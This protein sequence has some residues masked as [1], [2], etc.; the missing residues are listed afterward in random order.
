MH[1]FPRT[2]GGT[3]LQYWFFYPYNDRY[4]FF[5]HEGDWEHVTVHLDEQ[6]RPRELM[7]AQHGNNRPGESRPWEGVRLEGEHPIVLAARGDHASYPEQASMPWF[8]RSSG[9]AALAACASPIWR[10]WEGGGL[11]NIGERGA[12]LG[13]DGVFEYDGRW[14]GKGR[15]FAIGRAP[16]AP[17]YQRRSF[18]SGGF[19]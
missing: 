9:C 16:R 12:L 7:L 8:E 13:A 1:V 10:T 5:D 18:Q 4:G 15:W 17:P 6:R 11:V 19:D 3:N 14:G 2:D